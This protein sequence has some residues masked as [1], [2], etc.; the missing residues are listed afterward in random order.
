MAGDLVNWNEYQGGLVKLKPWL[1]KAEVKVAMGLSRPQS[2]EEA[3]GELSMLQKFA[4]EVGEA[5]E[6]IG[7]ITSKGERISFSA[8]IGDEIDAM[9]S[10]EA[11]QQH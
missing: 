6:M 5:E 11:I 9:K 3:V 2:I 1:E 8:S 4:Q 7:D 10:R